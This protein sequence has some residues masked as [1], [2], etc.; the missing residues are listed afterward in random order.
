[1]GLGEGAQPQEA[2][3]GPGLKGVDDCAGGLRGSGHWCLG[4]ARAPGLALAHGPGPGWWREQ[5]S[6]QL[7]GGLGCWLPFQGALGQC[8]EL[9]VP[10]SALGPAS[11][12]RPL[13]PEQEGL[14]V[15]LWA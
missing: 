12:S 9:A 13:V 15:S 8:P 7:A 3:W 2:S 5:S 1:M 10:G 14:V 11:S 6:L 4:G